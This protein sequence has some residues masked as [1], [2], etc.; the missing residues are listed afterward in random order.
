MQPIA[1]SAPVTAPLRILLVIGDLGFGGAERQVTMLVNGLRRFGHDAHVAIFSAVAPLAAHLDDASV[2]HVLPH[3]SPIAL[4]KLA[5]HLGSGV[6]HGFLIDAEILCGL[7]IHWIP[8]AIAIG[9]ERSSRHVYAWWQ[10]GLYRACT[11]SLSRYVAN[12]DEGQYWH[13]S[14]FRKA[15]SLY[16]VVRNGVDTRRFSPGDGSS[17]RRDLGVSAATLLI[18]LFASF[19]PVKNHGLLLRAVAEMARQ[20]F[21][22]TLLLV[23]DPVVRGSASSRAET[24]RIQGLITTLNLESRVIITGHRDD[25]ETLYR[26]CDLTVL[27]SDYEGTPNVVLESMACG[28]PAVVA[29]VPGCRE[30]AQLCPAARTF[31]PGDVSHLVSVL[32]R[33][34]E[35]REQ[36]PDLGRLGREQVLRHY[37][38]DRMIESMIAVYQEARSAP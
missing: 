37:G 38:E 23:G 7:A 25:P 6:L 29:E 9:S 2:L 22:V 35:Q 18:G 8:G 17:T 13:S 12:S 11:A 34:G 16:R 5:R 32:V 3:R 33:L 30:V 27:P 28:V 15:R 31:R 24:T 4:A 21:E 19:K 1:P 20:G 26:A 10:T 36:L 14:H